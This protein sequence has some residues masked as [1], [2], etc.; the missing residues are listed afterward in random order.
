MRAAPVVV[1]LLGLV[2]CGGADVRDAAPSA[3]PSPEVVAPPAP[4]PSPT[5]DPQQAVGDLLAAL[6]G[7]TARAW[8]LLT[9]AAQASFGGYAQ[10]QDLTTEYAEGLAQFVDAPRTAVDLG[11]G[12]SVVTAAGEVTREGATEVDAYALG[13][14]GGRVDLLSPTQPIAVSVEVPSPGSSVPPGAELRALVPAQSR[15]AVTVDGEQQQFRSAAADGDRQVVT[16]SPDLAPGDHVLTVAAVRAD[17]VVV[18]GAVAF[19]TR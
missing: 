3:S 5:A 10:F 15:P 6:G 11:D 1:L 4:S 18:A 9:D 13:V 8:E 14:R 12:R 19:T 16:L 17:G 2:A 7:D